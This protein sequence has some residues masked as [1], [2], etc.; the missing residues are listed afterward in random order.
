MLLIVT[1]LN[2]PLKFVLAK[3]ERGL[4]GIRFA[5]RLIRRVSEVHT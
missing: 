2:E 1:M 3:K 5:R 4:S